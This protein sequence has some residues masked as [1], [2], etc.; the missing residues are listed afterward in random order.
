LC[1]TLLRANIEHMAETITIRLD[2][3]QRRLFDAEAAARGVGPSTL[4]RDLLDER[5]RQLRRER[6]LR[7]S[8][9]AA[10][11]YRAA[12]VG[13]DLEPLDGLD[14]KVWAAMAPYE[15]TVGGSRP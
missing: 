12:I 14:P 2:R 8:T 5:L 4:A 6:I 15:G 3:E 10:E 9:E 7:Q 11:R 13:E 1:L